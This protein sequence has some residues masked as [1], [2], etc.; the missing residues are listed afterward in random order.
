M[1]GHSWLTLKGWLKMHSEET[2][3]DNENSEKKKIYIPISFKLITM[4][5]VIVIVSLLAVTV[6]ATY[7]FMSDNKTRAMEDTLNYSTLISKKVYSDLNSITEKGKLIA[8]NLQSKG[9]DQG[10]ARAFT[11][12]MFADDSDMILVGLLSRD[13][14]KQFLYMQNETFFSGKEKPDFNKIIKAEYDAISRSF[15]KEEVLFNPSV[16]FNEPVIGISFPYDQDKIDTV[17]VIFYSLDKIMESISSSGTINSFIVTGTGDV[18]AH[19]DTDIVKSKT[20]YSSMPIIQTMMINPNPNA[21]TSYKDGNNEKYLGAFSRIG[22]SD[23][24][25]VSYIKEDIAFAMVYKIQ[26]IL[27]WLTGIVLSVSFL[28]NIFFSRT[29]SNPI[30]KLTSASREIQKGNYEVKISSSSRDEIGILTDSFKDMALGLAERE[31][32]KS[33][34]GKFVNKQVAEL[35]LNNEIN[36]G[37]EKKDVAVFFSDIRS[38]TE[39]SESLDPSEVVE[40]LNDYMTRMVNCISK[41][42]GVV[43]KYIGDAI[44]AVWG[45]PVTTGDDAFNAVNSALLMRDALKEFNVGRGRDPKKPVVMIGCGI[46]F[47]PVLAGQIGSEDRMEYTVIGDTVNIAS[48]IEELNKP[49]FTDILI[50]E[51]TAKKVEDR[52]RIYPMQK[53]IV[54]GKSE[55]LQV[56]AV[57]GRLASRESPRNLDELRK[58]I[59]TFELHRK[60]DLKKV[61]QPEEVKYEILD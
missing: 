25:V 44:M 7:F 5:S 55:P 21:Q 37:G 11:E 1:K 32:I 49:F 26:R 43:D 23:A 54:Q 17:I 59:G 28:I 12:L 10:N 48:R 41:T 42:K 35:A 57:L 3:T 6:V 36:L 46:H 24:A 52:I 29:L 53:I 15:H 38:F 19:R 14:S 18:I 61:I 22:F 56:Y 8:I 30:R 39:I 33:A 20:N 58:L 51:E 4:I 16:Y 27:I 13:K 40:F 47:G 9:R 2:T 31:R 45:A 34:F 60:S 50:T